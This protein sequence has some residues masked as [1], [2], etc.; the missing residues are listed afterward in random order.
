MV[1]VLR[2]EPNS[3]IGYVIMNPTCFV[4]N[5]FGVCGMGI[6]EMKRSINTV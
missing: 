4:S 5:E 2:L 3:L 6:E 1:E